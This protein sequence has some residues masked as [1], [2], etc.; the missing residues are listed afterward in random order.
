MEQI[1]Q[2]YKGFGNLVNLFWINLLL[3]VNTFWL[4]IPTALAGACRGQACI[5]MSQNFAKAFD[6]LPRA[7]E[8]KHVDLEMS[9]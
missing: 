5:R 4:K 8:S 6:L 2:S 3:P 9:F 1:R 7:F